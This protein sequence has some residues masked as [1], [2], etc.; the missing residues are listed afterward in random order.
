MRN[1]LARLST[2]CPGCCPFL[3]IGRVPPGCS[4]CDTTKAQSRSL[5]IWQVILVFTFTFTFTH[6]NVVQHICSFSSAAPSVARPCFF[7]R[8]CPSPRTQPLPMPH[9]QS[10]VSTPTN[11]I[12]LN[13]VHEQPHQTR[14]FRSLWLQFCVTHT[15]MCTMP[16]PLPALPPALTTSHRQ[17]RSA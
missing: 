9:M 17:A 6:H 5:R 7:F 14:V 13:G 1:A 12:F 15:R 10:A 2:Y 4:P 3:A 11:A 16:R 8:C